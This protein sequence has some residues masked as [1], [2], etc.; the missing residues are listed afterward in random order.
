MLLDDD[1]AAE[2]D[3]IMYNNRDCKVCCLRMMKYWLQVHPD[4]NWNHLV[5]ALES[6]GVD[7]PAVATKL[8]NLFAG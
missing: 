6:P 2:L 5:E 1:Q 7:L 3:N 8:K 4:T